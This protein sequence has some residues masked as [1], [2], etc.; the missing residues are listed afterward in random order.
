MIFRAARREGFIIQVRD[1]IPR[2]PAGPSEACPSG[3]CRRSMNDK[4][5]T[6]HGIMGRAPVRFAPARK[7]ELAM[8]MRFATS[9]S[10]AP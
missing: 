7:N 10:Q 6:A 2:M 5:K 4:A 8:V 3:A 9:T 1:R